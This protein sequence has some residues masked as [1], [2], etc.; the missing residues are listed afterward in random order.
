MRNQH[1]REFYMPKG[2]LKVQ[3]KH[4][5][6]VAYLYTTSNGKPAATG[7][8]G[9]ADKPAFRCYYFT[10]QQREKA[11]AR[12]FEGEQ[13]REQSRAKDAAERMAFKHNYKV[14]DLF[15]TCWGYDQTNVEYFECV[16]VKGAMIVVREISCEAT[17]DGQNMSGRK[18]PAPGAFKG[19]P[20][21]RRPNKFGVRIDKVRHAS[22][23]EPNIVAGVK[24]YQSAH[25]SDGH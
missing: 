11:I 8:R 25:Y 1:K 4:S 22:F 5:S 9:R 19:K 14:G 16:E 18:V 13:R 23:I 6:A 10:E 20:L 24:V 7:F 21:L 17:Y 12:H 3:D 2:A 15:K